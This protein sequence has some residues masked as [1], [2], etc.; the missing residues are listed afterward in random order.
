L[1][2]GVRPHAKKENVKIVD[3]SGNIEQFGELE[4]VE[5]LQESGR[6]GMFCGKKQLTLGKVFE[7]D[8][9]P[10]MW[11]GKHSGK[12]LTEVPINY[13]KWAAQNVTETHTDKITNNMVEIK[14]FI[15]N[16]EVV[17]T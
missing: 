4:S 9:N 14:K 12:L 16:Q 6:W 17:L 2:R 11:F 8:P 1:G 5:F 10:K 7:V 3:F 13:L 15:K